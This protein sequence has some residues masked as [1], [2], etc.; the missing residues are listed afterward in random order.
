MGKKIG[1]LIAAAASLIATS[2]NAQFGA[3]LGMPSNGEAGGRYQSNNQIRTYIAA[4]PYDRIDLFAKVIVKAAEMT[5]DKGF[6][7]FGVTKHKC[8]TVLVNRSP[9]MSTCYVIAIMLADG[10]LAQARGKEKVQ[11][12]KVA[13]VMAGIIERPSQ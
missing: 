9:I 12:Y 6:P 4:Q 8:S 3:L 5:M 1:F 13:D 2:T 11:Y 10:E 7:V